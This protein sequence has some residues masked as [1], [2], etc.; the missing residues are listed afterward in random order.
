MTCFS[1]L[2]CLP[3]ELSDSMK[4]M[5]EK[6]MRILLHSRNPH[7]L[8]TSKDKGFEYKLTLCDEEA[9]RF[10]NAMPAPLFV[11]EIRYLYSPR[12]LLFSNRWLSGAEIPDVKP[13]SQIDKSVF[14]AAKATERWTPK[15]WTPKNRSPSVKL[16][17][18]IPDLIAPQNVYELYAP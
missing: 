12:H 1:I 2:V 14:W 6:R 16:K 9:I 10:L 7:Y 15:Q 11:K 18:D 3:E 17:L 13:F 4:I 8:Q 5:N